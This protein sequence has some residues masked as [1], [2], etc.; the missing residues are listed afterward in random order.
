MIAIVDRKLLL[1]V[2]LAVLHGACATATPAP[3]APPS[4][5]GTRVDS[6]EAAAAALARGRELIGR[7]EMVR[8]AIALREALALRPELTE[9]RTSLA[10]AL[11]AVGDVEG[12]L[13]ELR[14]AIARDPDAAGARALIAAARLARHEG[15]AARAD[16]EDLARRHPHRADI[17]YSLGIARYADRNLAGAAEAYRAVIALE[18]NHQDARYN[19]AL[20]L[21]LAGRETEATPEFLAAAEGGVGRAQYFAGV[22]L[23]EGLGV[24]A[25]LPKAVGWWMRAAERGV[26]PAEEALASL[27]Q[28]ALGRTR[29]PASERQAAEHAFREYRAGLWSELPDVGREGE[30]SLG[31]ALVRQRRPEAVTVLVREAAS[32]DEAA[33]EQLEILYE[34]GLAGAV[35]PYDSRILAWFQ[36][37]A[38]DGSTRPRIALAKVYGRGLGVPRDVPRA[39]ALLRATPHE[40]ARRLLQELAP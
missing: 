25:S 13:E 26:A 30:E 9:A 22:A 3:P 2:L 6:A 39:V 21:K 4:A 23:A 28:V 33:Q 14:A 19:L 34:H 27:R 12:A 24:P 36:T 32:L 8:A 38:A 7:G 5:A 17:F 11:Y 18:P 40:D 31:T 15:P 20:V 35:A 37:A 10:L 1:P 29:R 16:L